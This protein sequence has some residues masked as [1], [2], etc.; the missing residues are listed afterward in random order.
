[1]REAIGSQNSKAKGQN[2]KSVERTRVA[3]WRNG[4]DRSLQEGVVIR[5]NLDGGWG[6]GIVETV[7]RSGTVPVCAFVD[8]AT[9]KA[10]EARSRSG[11]G[12]VNY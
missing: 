8:E 10:L 1:M 9:R 7:P 4:R 2:G 3:I 6:E 11:V 5:F 12:L